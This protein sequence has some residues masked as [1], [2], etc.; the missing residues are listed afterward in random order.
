L[1]DFCRGS[2]R[3]LLGN[4]DYF[5]DKIANPVLNSSAAAD[6]FYLLEFLGLE[7]FIR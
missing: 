6:R 7:V 4:T 3:F 2:L 1:D 5:L